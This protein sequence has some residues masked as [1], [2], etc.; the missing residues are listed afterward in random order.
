MM[1]FVKSIIK[2]WSYFFSTIIGGFKSHFSL[3][4]SLIY[5]GLFIRLILRS[6]GLY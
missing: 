3:P 1:N 2:A 6:F 4:H 5:G